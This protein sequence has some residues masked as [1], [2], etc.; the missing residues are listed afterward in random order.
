MYGIEYQYFCGVVFVASFVDEV[1]DLELRLFSSVSSS[2]RTV[3]THVSPVTSRAKS[4]SH[5]RDRDDPVWRLVLLCTTVVPFKI[6]RRGSSGF[7]PKDGRFGNG[8]SRGSWSPTSYEQHAILNLQTRPY[9]ADVQKV[10]DFDL[11]AQAF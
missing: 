1:P 4:L 8:A 11:P 10:V 2:S 7:H 3:S 5:G 9:P 6:E